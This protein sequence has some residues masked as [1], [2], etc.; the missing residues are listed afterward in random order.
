MV[1][2]A[3]KSDWREHP[4]LEDIVSVDAWARGAVDAALPKVE[5]PLVTAV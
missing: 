4:S 1:M 3:H 5:K 2:E